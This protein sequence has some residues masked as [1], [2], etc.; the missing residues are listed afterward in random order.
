M[1]E[2]QHG[3]AFPGNEERRFVTAVL[4]RRMRWLQNVVQ[5][6]TLAAI[7][8][9][10]V[11]LQGSFHYPQLKTEAPGVRGMGF[12]PGWGKLAAAVGLRPPY[13]MQRSRSL[14]ETIL[15][16]PQAGGAGFAGDARN[17]GGRALA[18]VLHCASKP[19][20]QRLVDERTA[21]LQPLLEKLGVRLLSM[22]VREANPQQLRRVLAFGAMIAGT[23]PL[24][25][26]VLADS[27]E[28]DSR[29][30]ASQAPAQLAAIALLLINGAPLPSPV[31]AMIEAHQRGISAADLADPSRFAVEWTARMSGAGPLLRAALRLSR[32]DSESMELQPVLALSEKLWARLL[33]VTRNAP[34]LRAELLGPATLRLLL[35]AIE[36]RLRLLPLE[37]RQEGGRFLAVMGDE[38]I[39]RGGSEK[40]AHARALALVG[41]A[42]G[43]PVRSSG[44]WSQLS[45]ELAKGQPF[46][47]LVVSARN[48][49]GPPFD[50]LNRGPGRELC[51]K[52]SLLV[53]SRP[54]CRPT[55][56][57]LPDRM[58]VMQLA[59]AALRRE[60][61]EIFAATPE[62][63]PAVARLSRIAALFSS[64]KA[65][66]CEIGGEILLSREGKLRRIR[67]AR[68]LARPQ[69][70]SIDPEA[71][72]LAFSPERP[73]D[74]RTATAIIQCRVE[75][76]GA[77]AVLLYE[78][79]RGARLREEVAL[80]T[81]EVHLEE[82][83]ALLRVLTPQ[84]AIALRTGHEVEQAVR[85]SAEP[86]SLATVT[87]AGTLPGPITLEIAGRSF[88][89]GV[90]S[91]ALQIAADWPVGER[92]RIE[93]RYQP[94]RA[95]PL[96]ALY[97]RSSVLRRL[98]ARLARISL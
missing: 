42:R 5:P 37:F 24:E 79:A 28:G 96:L 85:T 66:A 20:E 70:C 84:C 51:L 59:A 54:G 10:P 30:L 35:P 47:A 44:M 63:Q 56:A 8:F 69:F 92:G 49:A 64:G 34:G 58:A 25:I 38:V 91:A 4:R 45:A 46:C 78:D 57:E 68:F 21:A 95:D 18:I 97:T 17:I 94:G 67:P 22:P 93:V 41:A 27:P 76:D 14:I 83:Q 16:L 3:A 29:A 2:A 81:L 55:A 74:A 1:T 43:E 61:V 6:K 40:L 82:T 13:A 19:E 11:L 48:V 60:R 90:D 62:A 98:K 77:N 9:L 71:P 36:K 86:P 39:A 75:L 88:N 80:Q 87:I 65:S 32:G 73:Q 15:I 23:F 72:D 52:D 33:R 7:R 89:G 12:R 26:V 50:P 53:R 31:A